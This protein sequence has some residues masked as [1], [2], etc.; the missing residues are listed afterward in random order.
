MPC[1]SRFSANHTCT[2]PA[3]LV[4]K[5]IVVYDFFVRRNFIKLYCLIFDFIASGTAFFVDYMRDFYYHKF[6][7]KLHVYS[8]V[9]IA[10]ALV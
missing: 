3:R 10:F 5:V 2:G 4:I 1:R 6:V 7:N 8:F 9:L